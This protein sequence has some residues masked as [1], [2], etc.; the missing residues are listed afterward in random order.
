MLAFSL[1]P[2]GVNNKFSMPCDITF[3]GSADN[4]ASVLS[5]LERTGFNLAIYNT[6]MKRSGSDYEYG[7]FMSQNSIIR[8]PIEVSA[9]DVC[10]IFHLAL[11]Y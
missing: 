9:D 3:W 8:A 1:V 4:R 6:S 11:V 2:F 5:E 7:F 10:S